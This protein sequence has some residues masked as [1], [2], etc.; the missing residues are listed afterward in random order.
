SEAERGVEIEPEE[1]E[2]PFE[3]EPTWGNLAYYVLSNSG[4]AEMFY[5]DI[6]MEA[7]ELKHQYDEEW[8]R[9][10]SAHVAGSLS[11]IM[12][13]DPRFYKLRRGYYRLTKN[14]DLLSNPSWANLAYFVLKHSDQK[15]RGMHLSVISTQAMELKEKH[16]DWRSENARTPSHTVSATMSM[17][18]RF[19][20]MPERGYWRLAA[21]MDESTISNTKGQSTENKGQAISRNDA[22]GSV[23]TRI[24]QIGEVTPL[25][26]GRT[27]YALGKQAHLMF[28]YSKAHYRNGEIEYF[29]GVTPQYFNRIDALGKGFV[30]FVLGT[31]EH[32][33]IVPTGVFSA[34]VDGVDPSGSGTWPIAFYMPE[35][36]NSQV[37][38]WVP[39]AGRE[40]V[41][42]FLDDYA[43]LQQALARSDSISLRRKRGGIRVGDLLASGLLKVGDV[44]CVK[45]E[46]SACATV[47][48]GKRQSYTE[49]GKQVT[50]W[51]AINIYPQ[52]VLKRTG[53]TLDQLRG[54]LRAAQKSKTV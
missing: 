2:V 50:G 36:D 25:S 42:V 15:R 43:S 29:L 14:N 26:F 20:S 7:E 35:N 5:K 12:S 13:S 18:H 8:M 32:V 6:A 44:V 48:D 34:W 9:G 21:G 28:R 22:Y 4:Q 40:D 49:W 27:Y 45:K 51:S 47:V 1:V 16:S 19:E 54:K 23:L 10:D 41:S 3:G 30:I 31:A 53:E 46:P 11:A 39:G 17:D 52:M 24:S 38:R 33:L 37:A